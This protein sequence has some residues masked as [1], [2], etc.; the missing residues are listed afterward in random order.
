MRSQT[1][2]TSREFASAPVRS[3][4]P[5][6]H[7]QRPPHPPHSLPSTRTPDLPGELTRTLDRHVSST[8]QILV[9][10]NV[11]FGKLPVLHDK[12]RTPGAGICVSVSVTTPIGTARKSTLPCGSFAQNSASPVA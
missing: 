4:S 11:F 7:R 10:D 6:M 3:H 9:F 12:N 5:D 1:P 8:T 2:E